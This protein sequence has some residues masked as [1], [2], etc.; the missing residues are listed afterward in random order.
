MTHRFRARIGKQGPNL[1]VDVPAG[2]SRAFANF[3]R[4]GRITF[5]GRLNKTPIRGTLIPIGHGKHRLYVNSGMRAA[6]G[7]G[8]DDTAWF[9]LKATRPEDV[10]PPRDVAAA[11]RRTAG[12]IAAFERLSPSHRRELL[13]Y[14]DDAR[15]PQTRQRRIKNTVE[16]SL[17]PSAAAAPKPA[18]AQRPLWTCPRCGNEFVNRNQWHSCERYELPDVFAGKSPRVRKLFDRFRAMVER[19]G[20]AKQLVYRDKIGYMVRVR[21]AGAVPKKNWL[22]VGFWLSRRIESPRFFKVETISPNVHAHALRITDT[23]QLD[24]EVAGWIKEAYAVGC[25]EH[26]R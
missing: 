23:D 14:I 8:V 10:R 18:M 25:Q 5:E 2:V 11:L 7:V 13:R 24:R 9:E 19:C 6:A 22:I 1:Y 16:H 12:A 20:P 4:N 17:G 21:F 3:A 15:T 26:L